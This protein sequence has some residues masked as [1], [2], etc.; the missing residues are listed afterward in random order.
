MTLYA[1]RMGLR[2]YLWPA[3]GLIRGITRSAMENW[4]RTFNAG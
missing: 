2:Q 3:E 4:Q 1:H